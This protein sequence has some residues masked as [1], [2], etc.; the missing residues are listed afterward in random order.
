GYNHSS[1]LTPNGQ[2]LVFTDEVPAGLPF[3]TADV[4]N[5]SNIQVLAT[6]NQ[7]PQ[8]TPHNVFVVNN[9]Y[10]F[11]SSYQ[12]GTQL[13]DISNPAT[14]TLAGFFD[15]FPQGGGN[16][17]NW[18]GDNYDGQ[19]A[20][21]PYFPSK[22]IFA[23][24]QKN[25]LFMLKT[26]LFQNPNTPTV[27]FVTQGTVCAGTSV[28]YTNTSQGATSYTWNLPGGIPSVS[29]AT[30]AVVTYSTA[31][32][33]TVILTGSNGTLTSS[34][35][36]TILVKLI[37]GVTSFT[38][39]S[40]STC[41]DGKASIVASGGSLPYTYSW[42]PFGGNATIAN[43]LT[44][45]CYTVNIADAIGCTASKTVCVG[46]STALTTNNL[47]NKVLLYPNPAQDE[48]IIEVA[49]ETFTYYLFNS[50]GQL[51]RSRFNNLNK[52]SVSLTDLPKG[53]Y[54]VEIESNKNTFRKKLITR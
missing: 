35:T 11:L 23:C 42:S 36:V 5:L 26:H 4:T 20:M 54:T 12:D 1:C 22:N 51:I 49:D 48:V 10:V 27:S 34:S 39:A 30:D 50:L 24:D 28:T 17:N 6:A 44:P 33:K 9:Q 31:G 3:K 16:N 45:A 14:P 15:T 18:S 2:T 7:F 8:G 47:E 53:V 25:G 13:Y 52:C 32:T 37:Q 38:N 43:S 21:Y 19:W 29:N 41:N 40:C 46:F